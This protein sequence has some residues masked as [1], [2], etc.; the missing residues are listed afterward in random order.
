[1]SSDDKN[2]LVW[3]LSYG[4]N[5]LKS[6]FMCYITGGRPQGSNKDYRGCVCDKTPPKDSRPDEIGF[7]LYFAHRPDT[8]NASNTSWNGGLA[9]IRQNASP[10]EYSTMARRYLITKEQ[11]EGVVA[12]ENGKCDGDAEYSFGLRRLLEN[13]QLS[14]GHRLYNYLIV[15]G[16]DNGVPII[17]LTT[18]HDLILRKPSL[19]YVTIIAL[20]L[21]ETYGMS[22]EEACSYLYKKDGI[23]GLFEQSD[24]LSII[25]KAFE[26]ATSNA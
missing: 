25:R 24:L 16:D 10:E 20:G 12:Q 13:R 11:L 19:E 6:R 4:S 2:E 8:S 9:F 1:M 21:R 5:L 15:I 18:S 26:D 3:Y 23:E 17:T 14:I 22:P 7:S